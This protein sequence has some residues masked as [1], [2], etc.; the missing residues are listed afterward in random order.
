MLLRVCILAIAL[1]LS[2]TSSAI[3]KGFFGGLKPE[4]AE[5]VLMSFWAPVYYVVTE[6]G[7]NV[8]ASL[9][10]KKPYA[11]HAYPHAILLFIE[12]SDA[13]SYGQFLQKTA[14]ERLGMKASNL[15]RIM[16]ALYKARMDP[17]S[18]DGNKPDVVIVDTLQPII[19]VIEMFVDQQ[20]RPYV[21]E[22]RGKQFIPAFMSRD[23]ANA[24]EA[25][26]N[27]AGKGKYSRRG[28]DFRSHLKIVESFVNTNTPVVTFANDSARSM[29]AYADNTD[30]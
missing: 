16:A 10:E 17:P 5:K 30:K 7:T 6:K 26:V 24:F 9:Q 20:Q 27:A 21:H 1:S 11:S 29:S 25:T 14:P 19:P 13:K 2:Q 23:G 15:N 18:N 12:E 8:A 28:I 3:D 4:T 22:L